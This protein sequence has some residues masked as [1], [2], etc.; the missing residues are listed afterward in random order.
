MT[1]ILAC[2]CG[3]V[4]ATISDSA[5]LNRAICYCPSCQAFAHQNTESL[6]SFCVIAAKSHVTGVWCQHSRCTL[7]RSCFKAAAP[8]A[9]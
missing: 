3:A 2:S 4:R 6:L 5:R 9:A 7:R 8:A 1:R